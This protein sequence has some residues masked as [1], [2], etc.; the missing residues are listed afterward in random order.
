MPNDKKE[1]KELVPVLKIQITEHLKT[2]VLNTSLKLNP[3]CPHKEIDEF[4]M[5]KMDCM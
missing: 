1:M 4:T 5:Q 3:H 2:V